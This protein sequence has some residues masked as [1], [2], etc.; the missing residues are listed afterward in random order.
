MT[1]LIALVYNLW[2]VFIR[3]ADPT[4]HMEALTTRPLLMTAVCRLARTG[5]R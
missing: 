4:R 3:L 1:A 5:R 2:N